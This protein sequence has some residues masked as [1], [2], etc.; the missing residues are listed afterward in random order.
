[1]AQSKTVKTAEFD[2]IV[3]GGGLAGLIA[4]HQL[5]GTGRKVA[6]ID[7]LDV[8]GGSCRTAQTKA[9]PIDHG[10]KFIPETQESEETLAWLETV[11]GEPI[12][13]KRVEAPPLTYDDG[14]FKPFV[15]F[16]DQKIE[17]AAEVSSYAKDRYLQLS[18]TPKDWI[19]KLI[20]TFT[21]TLMTQ[22]Y[23][24]K[25][26]VDDEFV[27]EIL[28]NGAK[29]LS[30]REV[31][32]C[33]NPQQL[34]RLLPESHVP[35]RLRQK[36]IKG[37]F[38]TSLNLDLVHAA[39]VT[40]S[41]SIHVLKGANE[42]PC[43]GLFREPTKMEDGKLVQISQWLTLVHRDIT[44]EPELVASALKQIK[45]QVKRAYENSLEG[46]I[47]ERIV[48]NPSSH[49]DLVGVLPEDGQWPKLQNLWVVSGLMDPNKNL[50]GSLR[51]TR[52]T[53]AALA[54]EPVVAIDQDTDLSEGPQPTA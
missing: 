50:I 24:T 11:L 17:S 1:M 29:R 20:E 2:S 4:A 13:L 18:T 54:G 30:G 36:L 10:L 12:Q 27:I 14:K 42:E 31:L 19:P 41:Q 23:A 7:G 22:S 8:L 33:A 52:R 28:V 16:G 32:F 37:E 5:E 34:A 51:Q 9:G 3:I 21:G 43:V 44:E 26:Q 47:Q 45:R 39:P 46:L 15:G 6:L 49:G 38:F 48:V 53:L 25:M 40:D 35:A